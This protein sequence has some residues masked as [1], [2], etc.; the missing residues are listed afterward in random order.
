MC[1][2]CNIVCY[3][4][5]P[6]LTLEKNAICTTNPNIK[7]HLRASYRIFTWK[8]NSRTRKVSSSIRVY[9]T[10]VVD[11]ADTSTWERTTTKL[12]VTR[13]TNSI[14]CKLKNDVWQC[15]HVCVKLK[16]DVWQCMCMHVCASIIMQQLRNSVLKFLYILIPEHNFSIQQQCNS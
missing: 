15:M 5:M 8:A 12:V 1:N 2:K 10:T 6:S 14:P 13:V 3:L 16:N 4:W 9:E 7:W 11:G